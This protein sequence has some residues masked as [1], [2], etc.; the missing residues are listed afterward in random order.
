MIEMWFDGACEPMNPGGHSSY[1]VVII[2]GK[3]TLLRESGYFCY[4][5]YSSNNVAEYMGF[6]RGL[7]FLIERGR[8][9][10]IIHVM[11]DSNLVIQQ[12]FGKWKI[13]KG[14]YVQHAL[15]AKNLMK[16][17][18]HISGEWIP[19]DENSVCDDLSKSILYDRG[20]RFRIKKYE[21]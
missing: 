7:S 21:S 5:K 11:G 19:R 20:I 14:I 4:G 15:E 9:D 17:F 10:Q 18:K 6:N 2:E 12:Q 16:K 3:E 13:K 8:N 1:G